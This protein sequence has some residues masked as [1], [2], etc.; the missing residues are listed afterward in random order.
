MTGV[1]RVTDDSLSPAARI[2]ALADRLRDRSPALA[3]CLFGGAVAAG[4]GL[5]AYAVVVMALWIGSP[6]PDSGPGG[7]TG[8][9]V[10]LWLLG[11]GVGLTRADTLTGVPAPL[12]LTPLLFALL[13]F[14]LV[15]RAA[16]DAAE[17]ETPE[18][19][20][21]PGRTVVWGVTGGYTAVGALA[22][23]YATGGELRPTLR[24]AA[25][26]LPLLALAAALTGLRSVRG[27]AADA[28]SPDRPG[29]HFGGVR[30]ALAGRRGATACR[31]GLAAALTLAG[32]GAVLVG[33]SLT[34]HWD[35]ARA[36]YLMLTDVWSGRLAVLLLALAL[37]PN[38]VIWGA[39]YALGTGFQVGTGTL[40]TPLAATSGPALPPFPL[41]AAVP[42][43]GPGTPLTWACAA[44]PVV[45]G[46][47]A[48][49]FTGRAATPDAPSG[50]GTDGA[51]SPWTASVTAG[52]A[53]LAALV[54][55]LVCAVAA[56][57]AGGPLGT[58]R[59]AE[60]GPVW[61]A[62]GGA[63]LAWTLLL[64]VPT[65]L[66]LRAWRL[67][68][69]KPRASEAGGGRWA[70][71]GLFG[72]AMTGTG[73]AVPGAADGGTDPER[74]P[75]AED[76]PRDAADADEPEDDDPERV[77]PLDWWERVS[78][79]DPVAA[80]GGSFGTPYDLYDQ[81]PAHGP[82]DWRALPAEPPA[83][84]GERPPGR[85]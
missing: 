17:P 79:P 16:R 8:T 38:A 10:S 82:E 12:G 59:L 32:G 50:T 22:A 35:P 52:T 45:A 74:R 64:G 71:A 69:R 4:L 48:G 21:I 24:E 51:P 27:R 53:A 39:A 11:H 57:A 34:L 78:R 6:Y 41:L 60:L 28:P 1:T 46:I 68:T 2:Q 65:A 7:A 47:T 83:L 58:G 31:A 43:D 63:A 61:W 20:E 67:R 29:G 25:W 33:V 19:P 18:A 72:I 77:D 9:A 80:L 26:H 30:A 70:G 84:P 56:R 66:A 73:L 44:I 23:L 76:E 49:W 81:L 3:G 54:A 42:P 13:P 75:G 15:R 36:S 14:W 40:V 55:G 37:L 62:A 5:G 85:E